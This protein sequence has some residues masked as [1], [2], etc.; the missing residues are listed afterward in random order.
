MTSE[1]TSVNEA[2]VAIITKMHSAGN[3]YNTIINGLSLVLLVVQS[4]L[5]K[6]KSCQDLN[7]EQKI[8]VIDVCR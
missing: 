8:H 4:D 3:S 5:L 1:I 6:N 7:K 2:L